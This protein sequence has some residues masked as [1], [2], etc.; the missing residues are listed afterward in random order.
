MPFLLAFLS[1][2]FF[3][4]GIA[5]W[6]LFFLLV[7]VRIADKALPVEETP[8]LGFLWKKWPHEEMKAYRQDLSEEE[9]LRP[10]NRFLLNAFTILHVLGIACLSLVLVTALVG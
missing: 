4:I 10:V 7:Q 1:G 5:F 6:L 2:V 8:G 3:I 9:R